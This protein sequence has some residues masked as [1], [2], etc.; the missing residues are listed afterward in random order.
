MILSYTGGFFLCID[1]I[2]VSPHMFILKVVDNECDIEDSRLAVSRLPWVVP[3][4]DSDDD[5]PKWIRDREAREQEEF[6]ELE[7]TR[8]TS[9]RS[10]E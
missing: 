1:S 9:Q 6:D 4:F 5:T 3:L 8:C 10:R 7:D 2:F